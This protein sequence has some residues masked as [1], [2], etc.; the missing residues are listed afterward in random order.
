MLSQILKKMEKISENKFLFNGPISLSLKILTLF[1]GILQKIYG[2]SQFKLIKLE[3]LRSKV[4]YNLVMDLSLFHMV[5]HRSLN[6][7]LWL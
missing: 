7:M 4:Y 1:N 6:L 5:N 3:A 2:K